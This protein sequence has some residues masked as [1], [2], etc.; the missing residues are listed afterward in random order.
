MAL[1]EGTASRIIT[2][3]VFPLVG[4]FLTG[5]QAW[6]VL[7]THGVTTV[8]MILLIAWVIGV[9]LVAYSVF[10][11]LRDAQ[12]EHRLGDVIVDLKDEY[13]TQIDG[14]ERRMSEE[15]EAYQYENA[16]LRDKHE[17][18]IRDQR[19]VVIHEAWWGAGGTRH[20]YSKDISA[21][22]S[23]CLDR[24]DKQNV[25]LHALDKTLGD[26][27]YPGEE[28]KTLFVRFSCHCSAKA[29]E[30]T[31]KYGAVVDLEALCRHG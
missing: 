17:R 8:S 3:Y 24:C 4:I 6:G 15:R 19:K 1:K 12:R 27:G 21:H 14:L 20:I 10:V 18:D 11:N 5:I 26:G 9:G 22:L 7:D 16:A 30:H 29:M 23:Y 2:R 31:F 28:W 13:K 25:E